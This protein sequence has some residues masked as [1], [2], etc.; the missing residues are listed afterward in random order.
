MGIFP[1]RLDGGEGRC[2]CHG[3]PPSLLI[4]LPSGHQG[5]KSSQPALQL[6][7]RGP[8]RQSEVV[9]IV[10]VLRSNQVAIHQHFLVLVAGIARFEVCVSRSHTHDGVVNHRLEHSGGHLALLDQFE[11][12]IGL[13]SEAKEEVSQ[14][15]SKTGKMIDRVQII[16]KDNDI[17]R[18]LLSK[19][20][21]ELQEWQEGLVDREKMLERSTKEVQNKLS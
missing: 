19:K 11:N 13:N 18:T 16:V 9:Q 5:H 12:V 2:I 3:P 17:E 21:T 6:E 8:F 14:T 15:L 4:L 20:A 7:Q 1:V 10:H